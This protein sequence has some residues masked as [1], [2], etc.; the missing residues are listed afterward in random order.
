MQENN[1]NHKTSV[2]HR[3][4]WFQMFGICLVDLVNFS[5]YQLY[6][7]GKRFLLTFMVPFIMLSAQTYR[8]ISAICISVKK[9]L[10]WI[11][12]LLVN[13]VHWS[14]VIFKVFCLAKIIFN[15]WVKYSFV[16][17]EFFFLQ[18]YMFVF[19]FNVLLIIMDMKW[20]VMTLSVSRCS[21]DC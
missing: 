19:S 6:F 1:D 18:I 13:K 17:F 4:V 8:V 12:E 10:W 7:L 11:L 9:L 16:D 21:N 20:L 2:L 3:F 5:G 14:R 15:F